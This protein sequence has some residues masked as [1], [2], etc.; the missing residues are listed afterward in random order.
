MNRRSLR[1]QPDISKLYLDGKMQR[2]SLL[3]SVNGGIFA[4]AQLVSKGD[5][6]LDLK[7]LASGAAIFTILMT[8]DIWIF[9]ADM[10]IH[11]SPT[12]FRPVGQAIL[13]MIGSLIVAGWLMV[14]TAPKPERQVMIS[15][16]ADTLRLNPNTRS[17]SSKLPSKRSQECCAVL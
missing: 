2:Y 11:R 3:F 16:Q 8:A 6:L 15:L 7:T 9:G 12:F 13:L 17:A 1:P 14:F 10:R 4:I 5:L